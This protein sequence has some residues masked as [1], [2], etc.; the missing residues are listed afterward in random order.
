MI[1]DPK[2]YT[3]AAIIGM[4]TRCK[5]VDVIGSQLRS[6]VPIEAITTMKTV[7]RN[8]LPEM[9]SPFALAGLPRM[10]TVQALIR[11]YC[12][13]SLFEK[14]GS[15]AIRSSCGSGK[16][17]TG[18]YLIR[19]FR[20]KTLIVSTRNAV[21]DQWET[22]IRSMYPFLKVSTNGDSKADIWLLTP[23]YMDQKRRVVD[24][25]FNIRP[26][27]I[28]YDEI[29]T[30]LSEKCFVN[31]LKYP[32]VRVLNKEWSELPY[33]LALSATY[34]EKLDSITRVFGDVR[35]A[36]TAITDIPVHVFDY[37]DTI[38]KR[39][40]C[41]AS[42]HPLEN[43]DCVKW[44][45][46]RIPWADSL[47]ASTAKSTPKLPIQP[48]AVSEHLKGLVITYTIMS[49]TWAALYICKRLNVNVLFVRPANEW[50]YFIPK[51]I[52][53]AIPDSIPHDMK[54]F[55]LEKYGCIRSDGCQEHLR[56]AE[57]VVST[58]QRM[59]EGFSCEN[60]VW[61]IVSQFP[62]SQLTRVQICGRVRRS[63]TDPLIQSAKRMVFTCSHIIPSD[64]YANGD[65]NP[66]PKVTYSIDFEREL[67]EE[68]N[69][70]YITKHD[71]EEK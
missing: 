18:M 69:I 14:R 58:I 9:G 34:P 21:I 11:S 45:V 12:K 3:L 57:V 23:Q 42:Y 7:V 60:I 63:S 46:E 29:H 54:P 59:K 13:N 2:A 32:F 25:S 39:G 55:D 50:N 28:I 71:W 49:S 27:L 66:N 4:L 62:Y 19:H 30:M 44:F 48:I 24:R 6:R 31:V 22:Q 67:F 65:Y 8:Q 52:R 35:V 15:I 26:G 16:T 47:Q 38:K 17:Y 33:M 5:H 36:K 20:C 51:S 68:E 61:A 41:D 37:R 70:K 1:A 40:K 56:H 53:T 64:R 10:T 43:E